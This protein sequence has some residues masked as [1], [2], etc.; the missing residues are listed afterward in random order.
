MYELIVLEKLKSK[1][2]PVKGQIR[3]LFGKGLQAVQ[4]L[5]SPPLRGCVATDKTTHTAVLS[6]RA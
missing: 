4:R 6:F 2:F 5:V 1:Y 3:E